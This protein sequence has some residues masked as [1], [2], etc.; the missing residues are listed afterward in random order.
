MILGELHVSMY[1]RQRKY[2]SWIRWYYFNFLSSISYIAPEPIFQLHMEF[3][4][5][6]IELT[7]FQ[8]SHN[9]KPFPSHRKFLPHAL[10]CLIDF[11]IQSVSLKAAFLVGIPFQKPSVRWLV[12]CLYAGV[13]HSFLEYFGKT[14]NN[15]IGL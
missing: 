1:R 12:C 4:R 5:I 2:F 6:V 10:L 14:L 7:K 8:D 9:Q 15:D 13:V 11:K 3:H